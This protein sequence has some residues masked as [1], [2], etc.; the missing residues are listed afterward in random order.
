M[1][2]YL[3]LHSI[4]LVIGLFSSGVVGKVNSVVDIVGEVDPSGVRIPL[5][6][7]SHRRGT[8]SS[9]SGGEHLRWRLLSNHDSGGRCWCDL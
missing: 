4:E 6:V 1:Q 3:V 9:G 5:P 8:H 2:F 7:F